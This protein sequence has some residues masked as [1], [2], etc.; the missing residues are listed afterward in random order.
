MVD[1]I[2]LVLMFW[3]DIVLGMV[4]DYMYGCLLGIIKIFLYKWFFLINYKK[5]FFIG[6]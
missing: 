3:F 5:D 2:S 1:V 4:F 6:G